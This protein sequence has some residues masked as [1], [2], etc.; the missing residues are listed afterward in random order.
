MRMPAGRPS[1]IDSR[2]LL[3]RAAACAKRGDFE[4]AMIHLKELLAAEPDHEVATGLLASIYAQLQMSDRATEF[5]LRVLAINPQNE[6][7]RVQLEL[8]K[9][10]QKSPQ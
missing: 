1:Q 2:D 7:A 10:Q 3:S 9:A 8:L 6:L 5:Y 4:P